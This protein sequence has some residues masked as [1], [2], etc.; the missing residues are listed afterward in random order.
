MSCNE[1]VVNNIKIEIKN[2]KVQDFKY[3]QKLTKYQ[4]SALLHQL[5]LNF[6][7]QFRI[8]IPKEEI[9]NKNKEFDEFIEHFIHDNFSKII[10]AY[11]LGL[12][13]DNDSNIFREE[14]SKDCHF[15]MDFNFFEDGSWDS[16][17]NELTNTEDDVMN[18][19][20]IV[21]EK[22]FSVSKRI[23]NETY[24]NCGYLCIMV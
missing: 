8:G 17:F 24:K 13:C 3:T 7:T 14:I 21:I 19:L 18:F 6:L 15:E 16:G 1:K 20:S 23:S 5:Y 9:D 12:C 22:C 11:L 2:N 4:F 10:F